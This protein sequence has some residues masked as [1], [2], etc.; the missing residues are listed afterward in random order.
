MLKLSVQQPEQKKSPHI[1][2]RN[3]DQICP[4]ASLGS[5]PQIVYDLKVTQ[6]QFRYSHAN[7]EA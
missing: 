4:R 3:R 2:S 6:I 7:N 5:T 1:S